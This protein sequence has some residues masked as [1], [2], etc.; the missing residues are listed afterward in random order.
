EIANAHG[1]LA[2]DSALPEDT[3]LASALM[4]KEALLY[5]IPMVGSACISSEV[6]VGNI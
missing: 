3:V 4:R 2:P 1:W 6:L 5:G